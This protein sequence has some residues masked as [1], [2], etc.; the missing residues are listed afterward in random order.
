M[1]NGW[2]IL[3]GVT[4]VVVVAV[5]MQ[6]ILNRVKA[7]L[8]SRIPIA[9]PAGMLLAAGLRWSHRILTA[10]VWVTAAVKVLQ[11]IP[12]T[13]PVADD[14]VATGMRAMRQIRV[15]LFEP[16]AK[17]SGTDVSVFTLVQVLIFIIAVALLSRVT[18]SLLLNKVLSR[19]PIDSGL[20]HAI[21]T[22]A[23]YLVLVTGVW[24]GLQTA[25]IDLTALTVLAGAVGVGLGFGLQNVANNFISGLILLFERP[26]KVGDRIEVAEINGKVTHIA[27]RSTTVLTNDNISIIV[28]NSSF[29]SS[30]VINWSHGDPKV[31][32]R[33][34]VGV[35]YGSDVE[36]VKRLLLE[37]AREN[38]D[39]LSEPAPRVIFKGF[40][41]SSLDFEL[42]IWTSQMLHRRGVLFSDLNFAIYAKFAEHAVEIP[43]PQRDLHFKLNAQTVTL[44]KELSAAAG[45]G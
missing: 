31:R 35:A 5:A 12:V 28:P 11:V 40:G 20:Q 7:A 27:A 41:D 43:F 17:V 3:V 8:G 14:F 23:K 21:A 37:V 6:W 22:F 25:G 30:N 10:A 34:P 36:L 45:S 1:L 24:V 13:Q 29:I 16:F 39:V 33:V 26:I 18:Y 4:V 44:F 38:N 42:R 2:S 9:T 19:A 15:A 32:F